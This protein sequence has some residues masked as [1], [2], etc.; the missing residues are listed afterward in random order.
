M[1]QLVLSHPEP[2]APIREAFMRQVRFRF[3][4]KSKKFDNLRDVAKGGFRDFLFPVLNRSFVDSETVRELLLHQVKNQPS[5]PDV[6]PDG[7]R[8][9]RC[10][11]CAFPSVGMGVTQRLDV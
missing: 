5:L 3:R 10:G 6:F 8:C 9:F 11:L 2:A 4:V 7:F 1:G